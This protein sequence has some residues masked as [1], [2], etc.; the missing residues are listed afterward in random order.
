MAFGIR[1][2]ELDLWKYEVSEG[3]IAFLTH[4]W[5]HPRFHQITTV[6]KAG[7]ADLEKL[8]N[9][10]KKYGLSKEWIHNRKH[11]PHFDLIGEKQLDIL[12]AENL[13]DHITRFQ[14]KN[15]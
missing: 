14:L 6:T 5:L 10:G 1:K 3:N 12:V 8:A 9:W 2:T 11:Y 4:Y 13:D 7:C 15:S